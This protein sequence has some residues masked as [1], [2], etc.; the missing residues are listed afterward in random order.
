RLFQTVMFSVLHV[1][2]LLS[3]GL[4]FLPDAAL[5]V[6]SDQARLV[7]TSDPA[8]FA[9]LVAPIAA[10]MIFSGRKE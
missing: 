4:S 8:K 9:W 7:F 6:F 2:L 1:G 3:V 10:M 5:N